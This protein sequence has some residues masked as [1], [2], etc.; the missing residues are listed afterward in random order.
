MTQ[1]PNVSSRST[2]SEPSFD[3]IAETKLNGRIPVR[4]FKSNRTG[5]TVIFCDVDGPVCNGYFMLGT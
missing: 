5:L 4:K 2:V 3:L 1:S